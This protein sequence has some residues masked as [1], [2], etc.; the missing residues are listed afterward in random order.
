MKTVDVEFEV[1]TDNRVAFDWP[2]ASGTNL[3]LSKKN[4]PKLSSQTFTTPTNTD[5]VDSSQGPQGL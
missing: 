2:A 4:P 3:K 5:Y 1:S